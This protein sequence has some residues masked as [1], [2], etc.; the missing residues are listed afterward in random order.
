MGKSKSSNSVI[1]VDI[2]T[3]AIKMVQLSRQKDG[4]AKLDT[5]GMLALGPYVDKSVGESVTISA[6]KLTEAV[7]DLIRESNITSVECGMSIP[8]SSSLIRIIKMPL[9]DDEKLAKMVPLEV[10]KYI[11]VPVEEVHLDWWPLPEGTT[12]GDSQSMDVLIVA[13]HN[14]V[15]KRL[16]SVIKGSGLHSAFFEIEIFS[17]IRSI[18]KDSNAPVLICDIGTNH[19][20]IYVAE[21]GFIKAAHVITKGSDTITRAMMDDQNI[22]REEAE[23]QKREKGIDSSHGSLATKELLA[24]TQEV[25]R[26]GRSYES[27]NSHK[28]ETLILSGGGA[29]LPGLLGFM[30]QKLP[31]QVTMAD[32]FERVETD[33]RLKDLLSRSGPEFGVALGIALRRLDEGK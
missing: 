26:V 7:K 20:K 19:T 5:Y 17:T 24:I 9:L 25:A 13:I 28:I 1:G 33:P 27:K 31:Q 23:I 21:R 14:E 8:M 4:T 30:S 29:L 2:S 12:P 11:P 16:Q 32:P 10:R 18:V 3:S 22:S 15:I 6:D